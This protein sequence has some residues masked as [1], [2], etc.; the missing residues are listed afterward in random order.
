MC[1]GREVKPD[2]VRVR[3]VEITTIQEDVDIELD[4]WTV[5]PVK[6]IKSI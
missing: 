6:F 4:S 1:H 2:E 3:V 5:I